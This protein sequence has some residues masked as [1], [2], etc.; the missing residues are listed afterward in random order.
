VRLS[1]VIPVRN[2]ASLITEQLDALSA[3]QWDGEWEV[4]V[5]DNGSTD[6]TR[7][8]VLEYADR[9]PRLRYIFADDQADQ[10]YAANRGV[11]ASIGDAVLFCDADDVVAS[12]WLTAMADGLRDHLVVTG[13]NEL[14]LLN[15]A[16]L[17]GSRGRSAE[18]SVGSF[19]GI[20]PLVRGNNYGVRR[21]VWSITGP[22]AEGF[23]RH[24][25]LADQEFALRCWMH[26]IEIGGVAGGVVHYRYR[27]DARALWRQGLAYGSHRPLIARMLRDAGRT[28]PSKFA[29]WKSWLL[30]A[31][32]LPT[33]VTRS[34]RARWLWIA[35]NRAGQILGSVRYRI[36]ML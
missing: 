35:G 18:Q 20:F 29:G 2:E 1:V 33:V 31:L 7:D 3:Q 15:P 23:S 22:L 5:V 16:W 36:I 12:G 14:D 25:V 21:E 10:S 24:G 13:P 26:G 19:F 9:W 28:T 32:K 30:V 8:V 34:G 17:A 4:I 11:E 27:R 6:G